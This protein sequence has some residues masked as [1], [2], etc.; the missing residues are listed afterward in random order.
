METFHLKKK[1][2]SGEIYRESWLQIKNFPYRVHNHPSM[3]KY[4]VGRQSPF[5]GH[6]QTCLACNLTFPSRRA[7]LTHV[8][9]D[10]YN[11]SHFCDQCGRVFMS[12]F[13]LEQHKCRRHRDNFRC[14][15][16]GIKTKDPQIWEGHSSSSVTSCINCDFKTGCAQSIKRHEIICFAPEENVEF[17]FETVTEE[18]YNA[19]EAGEIMVCED[20]DKAKVAGKF[21]CS[22][23]DQTFDNDQTTVD[24]FI[25]THATSS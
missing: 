8:K 21:G 22:E 16:C 11:M 23:C 24:H 20:K 19:M 25:D 17:D 12:R 7:G 15:D 3:S 14:G 4:L 2:D 10:H 18:E 6:I 9:I 1:F 5:K 13:R